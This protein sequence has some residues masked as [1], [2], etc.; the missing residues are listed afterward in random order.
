MRIC[1]LS[2]DKILS[3]IK[4][5]KLYKLKKT[6]HDH[7]KASRPQHSI[8]D[9]Y[10]HKHNFHESASEPKLYAMIQENDIFITC[11]C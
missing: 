11:L 8:L 4:Q 9:S 1:I 7:K 2:R 6:L 5:S 3:L 10:F